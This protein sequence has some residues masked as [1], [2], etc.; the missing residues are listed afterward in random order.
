MATTAAQMKQKAKKAPE[1]DT[2]KWTGT[3]KRGRKV[4]GEMGWN[5]HCPGPCAT[6][7]PRHH[8][9]QGQKEAEA[10]VW[11]TKKAITPADVAVFTRQLATMMKAGVP[12][13]Q[14]FEIVADGL[15]NLR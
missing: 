9:G 14:A 5:Q 4:S 10:P 2:F 8:S 15:D 12:L 11:R 1:K 13:V 7:P 6:A 3:D